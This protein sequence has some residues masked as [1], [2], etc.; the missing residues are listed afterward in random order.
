MS[1]CNSCYSSSKVVD[2]GDA[3]LINTVYSTGDST[4]ATQEV[5]SST[6]TLTF[7]TA[8][9]QALESDNRT[10]DSDI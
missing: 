5:T 7:S 2:G 6:I 10:V 1:L 4:A 9:T 8:L 3:Q